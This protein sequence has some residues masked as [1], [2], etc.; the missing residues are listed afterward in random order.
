MADIPQVTLMDKLLFIP[1]IGRTILAALTRSITGPLLGGP[2]A[3][4]YFKDVA[5]AALR[6][7][8]G[9]VSAATEQWTNPPTEAGYL[10]LAKT[11][12]FQPETTVL[13]EGLK[14]HWIGPKTAKKVLL[15]FHGGGYVLSCSPGHYA[16]LFDLQQAL[17]KESSF[18][19]V[20]VG[21]TLA[22]HGQYPKQLAEAAESLQWLLETQGYSP[23]DVRE[24]QREQSRYH[25][26]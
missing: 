2:R 8:L 16:W 7:M 20:L 5:F 18:S 26:G 6:T 4:T 3:N 1:V 15:Y 17:A 13:A 19:I 10:E 23:S 12:G 14:L 22:P 9:N 11:K 25:H 21:Y 24:I